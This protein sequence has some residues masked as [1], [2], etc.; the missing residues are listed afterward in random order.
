[1]DGSISAKEPISFASALRHFRCLLVSIGIENA[2]EFTLH[3]CKATL[4]SWYAQLDMDD[5]QRA[6]AGHHRLPLGHSVGLYGR[7]DTF[8]PIKLQC[9]AVDQ[10]RKGW[11]PMRAQAR[12]GKEPLPEPEVGRLAAVVQDIE[13]RSGFRKN[14]VPAIHWPPGLA[15]CEPGENHEPARLGAVPEISTPACDSEN[16]TLV[17]PPPPPIR[18]SEAAAERDA[19]DEKRCTQ[20]HRM[21]E[22]RR[23]RSRGRDEA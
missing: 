2:E 9:F 14:W 19:K 13:F 7:D 8:A 18:R 16:Q 22:R 12:G 20:F 15:P 4:L 17:P 3:S 11:R 5:A 6:K 23:S 1:M 21:L 10:I